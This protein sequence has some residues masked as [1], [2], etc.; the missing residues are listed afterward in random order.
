M[1]GLI[2]LVML[3][4]AVG[5]SPARADWRRAESPNFVLYGTESESRLRERIL[6]LEDFDRLLRVV[7]TVNDPPSAVK[8]HIYIVPRNDDLALLRPTR[9][10]MA[11]FYLATSDGIGAFVDGSA[12]AE[13]NHVLFHEYAHHFMLHY[14]PNAYPAW[15]VE[16]F[17]EYFATVRFRSRY[18][19]IGDFSRG[20]INTIQHVWMPMERVL[21]G[22][23]DGLD[24]DGTAAFYAQS[25]LAVHWFY[26]TPERQ[27]ALA[28]YLVLSRGNRATALEAAIGM[29]A[30]R[31]G[32]ELREYI[33][34]GFVR[35]RRMERGSAQSPPTVTVTTMPRSAD[36]LMLYEAALRIGILDD[37]QQPYLQRI[38]EAA[39]RHP[40]DAFAQ[41]IQAHAEALYGDAGAADRLL[42]PLIADAPADAHLLYL[43]G[44]RHFV[45]GRREGAPDSEMESA[46]SWFARALA[47]DG[48]YFPAVVRFSESMRGQRFTDELGDSVLRAHA[49]A[50]Q[51]ASLAMNAA[52]IHAGRGNLAEALRLLGP[53]AANPHDASVARAAREMLD[54]LSSGAPGRRISQ[55]R[56]GAESGEGEDDK[57]AE[58][59]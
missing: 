11:G 45:A 52:M 2:F 36:D 20:R 34:G 39:A 16:G 23:T 31:F 35:M 40:D 38:R 9:A 27:A 21:R 28:R 53:L 4:L 3:W 55:P 32:N 49:A 10:G 48:K 51:V 7:T 57:P 19:D 33:R 56:T 43:K 44:M 14:R 6:L 58:M 37:S 42:D 59:D 13:G 24:P 46:R 25:W 47:A 18:I 8:L 26:S 17:A 5:V 41:R 50:P 29:D 30:S 1:R 15:Y 12:R 54:R 22:G